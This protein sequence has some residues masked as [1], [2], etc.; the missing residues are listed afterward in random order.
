MT[1]SSLC[2]RRLPV[3]DSM[4]AAIA[5][6]CCGDPIQMSS[7]NPH[8]ARAAQM[9]LLGTALW[10]LSF[11]STKAIAAAHETLLPGANSWFISALCVLYRF[12]IAALLLAL[13]AVRTL[14]KLT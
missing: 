13:L 6:H 14:P 4:R 8:S 11:P 9:L 7:S 10:A 5:A 12:A 3:S 1:V 2:L